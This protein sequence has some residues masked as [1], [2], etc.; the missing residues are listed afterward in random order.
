MARGHSVNYYLSPMVFHGSGKQSKLPRLTAVNSVPGMVDASKIIHRARRLAAKS[1]RL[2]H[3]V[4]SE[5]SQRS[6]VEKLMERLPDVETAAD[7]ANK[8]V[9]ITGSTQGVGRA[10]ARAFAARGACVVVNGRRPDAVAEAVDTLSRGGGNVA[11]ILADVATVDGAKRLIAETVAKFGVLD[12][13][14]NNAAIAGPLT[15]AWKIPIDA[16]EETLRTNLTGPFLC[17]REAVLWFLAQGR[18]GRV[19][20]VSTVTTEGTYPKFLA[21]TLTKS[22]LEVATRQFAADLPDARVII[23]GIILPSVQ[24][25]RKFAANWASTELLPPVESVIPAFEHSATAPASLLHGR[26]I[27]ADRFNDN[28]AAESRL[29]ELAAT[30]RRIL[31]PET[32][33][34]GKLIAR[35]PMRFTL[36]DRAENQQ[37]TSAQV[38]TAIRKSLDDHEPA[39]YPDDRLTELTLALAREHDLEPENFAIGPGS[40][41]LINRIVGAFAKPGEEVVSNAPGW[42]GFNAVCQRH[43]VAQV[44]VPFDVGEHCGSRHSHNLL[45]IRRAITPR[46]RLVYLIT[47]SNPEGVTLQNAEVLEFLSDIPPDL[48]ILIDE[49]Y[50]E[51]ASDTDMVDLRALVRDGGRT[52]IGARTFSKFYALAG[53]RVGYAY[54]P[55]AIAELLRNQEFIFSV[56]HIAQVAAVAALSDLEHRRKVFEEAK[57]ARTQMLK[58]LS[59]LGMHHIPSQAPYILAKRPKNFDRFTENLAEQGLIVA[60]YRFYGDEMIMLPVGTKSQN[61]TILSALCQHL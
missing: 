36:L 18:I 30:R 35:D 25:E 38:L 4:V 40:W 37:G 50:V 22:A 39:Y 33:V 1:V 24:T 41:E 54:A 6:D 8:V 15:E 20:N 19:I 52:I 61:D 17:M 45:G 31:Y 11:G 3:R 47:P 10:V 57:N 5:L 60:R 28:A 32:T 16:F 7:L 14:V 26:I 23:T 29:A 34:A 44:R 49:A 42:F 9:V 55:P 43:G 51:Y 2:G 21:Y 53:L 12:I 46:T 13:L 58:G 56:S 59:D 27:S 48:P